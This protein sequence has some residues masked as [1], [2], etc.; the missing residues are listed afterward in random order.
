[1]SSLKQT[2]ILVAFAGSHGQ[3]DIRRRCC[4][5]PGDT[6]DGTVWWCVQGWSAGL[7]PELRPPTPNPELLLPVM[8]GE[9]ERLCTCLNMFSILCGALLTFRVTDPIGHL[10]EAEDSQMRAR[11]RVQGPCPLTPTRPRGMHTPP[12]LHSLA[13]CPVG[14][15]C[16][17]TNNTCSCLGSC[18][19]L[20]EVCAGPSRC[21]PRV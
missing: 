15:T 18:G 3:G 9:H 19:Q 21:G 16:I 12:V 6:Y 11:T 17:F 13:A 8:L 2:L 14:P 1:M 7:G 5:G 20:S 10:E 4:L